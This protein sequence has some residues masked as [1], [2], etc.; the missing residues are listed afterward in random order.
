[1]PIPS[2]LHPLIQPIAENYICIEHG[3]AILFAID[4]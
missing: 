2:A 1:M 3:V 4:P